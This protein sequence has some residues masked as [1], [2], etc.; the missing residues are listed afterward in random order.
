MARPFGT[1]RRAITELKAGGTC[2]LRGGR[3]HESVSLNGL[4]G[5][6]ESPITI[7]AYPGEEAILDGTIPITGEWEPHE[8]NVWKTKL[9]QDIWQLFADG[10]NM[11][12]AR[13]PNCRYWTEEFWDQSKSWARSADV[14]SGYADGNM[15]DP[16]LA[17]VDV[18]LV[19]S[20]VVINSDRWRSRAAVITGHTPGTDR[21]A[22]NKVKDFRARGSHYY[23]VTGLAL[24]DAEEEWFYDSATR[25]LYLHSE[26]D[27][28]KRDVRGRVLDAS[29]VHTPT[30]R[31]RRKGTPPPAAAEHVVLDGLVFFASRVDLRG[32]KYLTIR[33][34]K[35]LYSVVSRRT[36]GSTR[37]AAFNA[38]DGC[39]GLR[40][41]NNEFRFCDGK[42]LVANRA[43][44]ARIENCLFHMIDFACIAGGSN[45]YTVQM[46]GGRNLVYRRN[47]IDTAGASE[48]MRISGPAAAPVLT[49]YNFHTRC[50]L[51]QT[52]GA[53]IQYPPGGNINSINRHNWFINVNRTGHRFDGDPGGEWGI[54]YRCVSALGGHRGFRF[55]GDNHEVYHNV[56]MDNRRGNDM[57]IAPNKGPKRYDGK[58]NLH[59]RVKNNAVQ[60]NDLKKNLIRDP[61]GKTPNWDVPRTQGNLRQDLRDPNNLDFR[62]R[63][64]SALIDAG[65]TIDSVRLWQKGADT[66][67]QGISKTL[68]ISATFKGA[69]PDLGAYEYGDEIY[70]LPGRIRPHAARPIPPDSSTTAKTD[71]DLMWLGGRDATQYNV[72]IGS[73]RGGLKLVSTQKTNIYVPAS[74]WATGTTIYWRVDTVTAERTVRG[75]VWTFQAATEGAD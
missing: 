69:A 7:R 59:S 10:R 13:W 57:S 70:W 14:K 34:S 26:T 29:L 41:I 27:P 3:Y 52:D 17:G 53:S 49:E 24:L 56:A 50:G 66:L 61:K 38:F 1:L 20:V 71:A 58:A 74:P 15:V 35:F 37:D 40:L 62:P 48:G 25:T 16:D 31:K 64:G 32:L 36:L 67:A 33:N 44:D 2:N 11:T 73:K 55:K 23:F 63:K 47:E 19:G 12:L 65:V 4:R 39:H 22:F 9:Q 6:M 21:F 42:S 18:S 5:T 60:S 68:D 43:D 72:Y 45:S 75:P 30:P 54:V 28:G 8:D 51:M 46:E